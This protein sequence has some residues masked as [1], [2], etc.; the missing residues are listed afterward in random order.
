M[1][2]VTSQP[3]YLWKPVQMS[4]SNQSYSQS[5]GKYR[6]MKQPTRRIKHASTSLLKDCGMAALREHLWMCECSTEKLHPTLIS[7]T[8]HPFSSCYKRPVK[9]KTR[10]NEQRV[11]K[12]E[13]TSFTPITLSATGGMANEPTHFYKRMAS[14]LAAKWG[15]HF[16]TPCLGSAA[17]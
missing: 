10:A 11:R 17:R 1:R 16:I 14:N 15:Q 6:I 5:R 7:R 2:S 3:T 9:T 8:P 13:H 4:A 12:V